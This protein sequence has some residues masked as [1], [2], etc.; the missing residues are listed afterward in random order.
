[1]EDDRLDAWEDAPFDAGVE[2]PLQLGRVSYGSLQ[3][4]TERLERGKRRTMRR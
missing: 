1:M 4:L 3:L 2:K